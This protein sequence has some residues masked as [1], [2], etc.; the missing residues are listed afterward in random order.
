VCRW[1]GEEFV[2]LFPH[3]SAAQA[4]PVTQRI[5]GNLADAVLTGD[6][7]PF[8]ISVGIAD[9]ETAADPVEVIRIADEAMFRAKQTG[10]D[11]IVRARPDG[12]PLHQPPTVVPRP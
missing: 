5:A 12:P 9:S 2:I 8:T 1:G 11:R 10:R 6:V 3:T 7:P 4:E